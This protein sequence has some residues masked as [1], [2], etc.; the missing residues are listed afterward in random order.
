V[1]E[2]AACGVGALLIVSGLAHLAILIAGG[3]TWHGPVSLRKPMT[4]GVSFGLTLITI[5]WVSGYLELRSRT[6]AILIGVFSVACAIETALVTL[7]AWRGVPSH[8]NLETTFDAIVARALAAGGLTLVAIIV[9][10]TAF[11]FRDNATVPRSL[12]TAIRAGFVALLGAQLAGAAMIARGM[13]LAL[14]GNPVAA[15]VSG[16]V[17]KPA[18]AVMMHGVLI[19]P[20]LA[21]I[22]SFVNWSERRRLAI[23]L[24]AT[25]GYFVV[26]AVVTLANLDELLGLNQPRLLQSALLAIGAASFGAA[27]VATLVGVVQPDGVDGVS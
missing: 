17:L 21:W 16:G 15:Y 4:F 1:A 9:S 11:A 27:G 25:S 24:L 23:V 13:R 26:S 22:L 8:F 18:H 20:A 2:R 12:L 10:L 3:G 14:N 6:R 19:L 7:Q 5:V